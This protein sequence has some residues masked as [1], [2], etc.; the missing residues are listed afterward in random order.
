MGKEGPD[1]IYF[2]CG[3]ASGTISHDSFMQELGIK[4]ILLQ[5]CTTRCKNKAQENG[6]NGLGM[7]QEGLHKSLSEVRCYLVPLL[8]SCLKD[9]EGVFYFCKQYKF[10]YEH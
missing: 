1:M 4:I 2:D 8:M 5:G 10:V 3:K 6:F 9:R 7:D